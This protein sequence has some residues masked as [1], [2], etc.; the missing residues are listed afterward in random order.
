MKHVEGPKIQ[1]NLRKKVVAGS[2]LDLSG[3]TFGVY[4]QG[5][6]G[7]CYAYSTTNGISAQRYI[8][9]YSANP[10]SA[11]EMSDCSSQSNLSYYNKGCGGGDLQ[12]S[13][14]YVTNFGLHTE[15]VYPFNT[16]T[17]VYGQSQPCNRAVN[18][19]QS[20]SKIRGWGYMGYEN[21]CF[22]RAVYV[23]NGYTVPTAFFASFATFFYYGSG[24]FSTSSCPSL[25]SNAMDHAV[26]IVGYTYDGTYFGNTLKVKNSWG[27]LW[28]E[29]GYFR[30]TMA[31][32]PCNVCSYSTPVY[33]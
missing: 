16:N 31:G 11:Q 6:C 21:N 32:N 33:L 14:W 13:L 12:I 9:G 5:A 8:S 26:L 7:N 30:I 10:L 28:G 27:T 4:N 15:S 3:Y 23:A 20:A 1:V 19:I 25:P 17:L 24:V 18:S 22:N 2:A 29:R